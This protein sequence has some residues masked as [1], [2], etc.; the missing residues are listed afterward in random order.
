MLQHSEH[1]GEMGHT[2]HQL[3]FH[4]VFST[5]NRMLWISSE[6]QEP[7][8]QYM[9]GIVVQ[10]GGTMIRIG[11]MPDHVHLLIRLK[12]SQLVSDLVK[13]VKGGSSRWVSDRYQDDFQWQPGYAVFSVSPSNSRAV[14]RYIERQEIHHRDRTFDQELRWLTEQCDTDPLE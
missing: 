4:V 13:A 6:L 11:G 14:A 2:Y 12:P 7:L 5:K 1:E 10:E 9:T 3:R 8:Y